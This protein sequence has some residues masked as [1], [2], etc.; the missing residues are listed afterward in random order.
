MQAPVV[1]QK[2][3]RAFGYGEAS[4]EIV[5]DE[6]FKCESGVDAKELSVGRDL[7]E[8][9][10]LAARAKIAKRAPDYTGNPSR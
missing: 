3:S 4:N 6:R 2:A 5:A 8:P 9:K 10:Y 1:M 7:E